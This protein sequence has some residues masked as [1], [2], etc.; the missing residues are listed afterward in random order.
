MKR[1]WYAER[2]P[3]SV[4]KKY[5]VVKSSRSRKLNKFE[6]YRKQ[7]TKQNNRNKHVRRSFLGSKVQINHRKQKS[8]LPYCRHYNEGCCK[9]GINCKFQHIISVVYPDSQKVFL[10]GLPP[11]MTEKE[12]SE[13]L[14]EKGFHIINKPSIKYKYKYTPQVCLKSVEEAKRLIE[15]GSIIID[16]LEVDVRP[17]K[18][19]TKKQQERLIDI[20]RRSV[21]LGGLGKEI[22]PKII[23]SELAIIGMSVVNRMTVKPGFCPQVTLATPEQAYSLV[24]KKKLQIKGKLVSVRPFVPKVVG[25]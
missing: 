24:C 16:G 9:R 12:L 4:C 5:V 19:V 22:T 14:N 25:S 1:R 13:K 23:R 7:Q 17:Y 8:K 3:P 10:G 15:K 18:A 21:F 11:D 20:T 6:A 2:N